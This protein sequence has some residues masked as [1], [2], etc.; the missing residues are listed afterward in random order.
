MADIF[1]VTGPAPSVAQIEEFRISNT[2]SQSV[3][4][5]TIIAAGLGCLVTAYCIVQ[6]LFDPSMLFLIGLLLGLATLAGAIVFIIYWKSPRDLRIAKLRPLEP[7]KCSE[8]ADIMTQCASPEVTR[9]REEVLAQQREFCY[10]DFEA[11]NEYLLRYKAQQSI[12][13]MRSKLYK[14]IPVPK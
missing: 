8:L 9:Y 12:E 4:W 11:I 14:S 1:E 3:D 10:G 5:V 6:A 7:L 13:N 2:Y